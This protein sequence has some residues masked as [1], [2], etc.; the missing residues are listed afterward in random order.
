[1]LFAVVLLVGCSSSSHSSTS[2]TSSSSAPSSPGSTTAVPTGAPIVVGLIT[3]LSGTVA[4]PYT[5]NAAQ[6]AATAVNAAGG[7]N[8]RP[9]KVDVCDNM[10][11]E[12][13]GALCAQKLLEQDKVLMLVG[14]SQTFDSSVLPIMASTHTMAWSTLLGCD[15]CLSDPNSYSLQPL[16]IQ[17]DLIPKMLPA[18]ANKVAIFVADNAIAINATKQ[19]VTFFPKTTKVSTIPVPLAATDMSTPCL[20]AKELGANAA[21][22]VINPNQEA[23][24]M[25]TCNQLGLTNVTWALATTTI[26]PQAVQTITQLKL[27]SVVALDWSQQAYEAFNAD[28]AKY[29]SQ[30]GGVSNTFVDPVMDPYVGI[31]L[32]PEMIHGAGSVNGPA[33]Q[34]WIN[35]QTAFNTE[36]FTPPINFAA[37]PIPN[38]PRVKNVSVFQGTVENNQL[39]QT[40]ATPFTLTG[41]V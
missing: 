1:V 32:L 7:I 35:R 6:L 5:A 39:V 31:K 40:N 13:G 28:L 33:I 10:S 20:R 8:G 36:G 29:G 30:V 4:E 15:A 41:K 25:Q 14:N 24:L 11:T 38:L 12:Q 17:Y 22:M 21:V 26:T 23:T 27:K 37:T 2:A 19:T 34:A 3:Q 9:V 18:T 16:F